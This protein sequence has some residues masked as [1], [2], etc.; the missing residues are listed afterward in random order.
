[1]TLYEGKFIDLSDLVFYPLASFSLKGKEC[2]VGCY[3]MQDEMPTS[4]HKEC[5][6]K[7]NATLTF[8]MDLTTKWSLNDGKISP[9]FWEWGLF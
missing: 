9:N 6:W 4:L 5:Q 7:K 8:S 2:Y 3:K 1:M